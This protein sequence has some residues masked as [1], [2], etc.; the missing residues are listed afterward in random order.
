MQLA[1]LLVVVCAVSSLAGDWPLDGEIVWQ[2]PAA[3]SLLAAAPLAAVIARWS[4][5]AAITQ[6][7]M[8]IRGAQQRWETWYESIA[9][10]WGASALALL[11][12]GQWPHVVRSLPLV[13]AWP[14]VDELLI[15]L[16]LVLSLVLVWLACHRV[17]CLLRRAAGEPLS[18]AGQYVMLRVRHHLGL[19]LLPALAILGIQETAVYLNWTS[20]AQDQRAWWLWGVLVAA[21]VFGLPI[22]LKWLWRAQQ[23]ADSPLKSRLLASCRA[24]GCGVR[25]IVVWRT[26]GTL[27]NAA[28]AGMLPG[29]RTI[30]LSDGLLARLTDD[31]LDLVVR[32]EAAHLARR[33]AWQRMMLL[34][35][36]LLIYFACQSHCP[37][38]LAATSEFLSQVGI[39]LVW[40]WTLLMPLAVMAY[41]LIMMGVVARMHEHDA[42]LAACSAGGQVEPQSIADL[43]SALVKL[44]GDSP[45]YDRRR[46]LHPS[47]IERIAF[48]KRASRQPLIA[49]RFRWRIG[50]ISCLLVLLCA[51][52]AAAGLLSLPA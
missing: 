40:Q 37:A 22:L 23:V 4:L 14:L 13:L 19:I 51:A 2:L 28:V 38:A 3:F 43:H 11:Y 27:A 12:L 48:L 15:L 21:A 30:F 35:V 32:H 36:P 9:W 46:W 41:A 52:A 33:H 1:I 39:A 50:S 34:A 26:G 17:E 42:D 29:M 10:L 49:A 44:V 5:E 20:G 31:E 16:P 45:E 7:R 6:R 18:A 47:V 8:T 24:L 25:D